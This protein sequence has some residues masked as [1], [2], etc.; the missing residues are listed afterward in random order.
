MKDRKKY[1]DILR[2]LACFFVVVN[3]FSF[4]FLGFDNIEPGSITYWIHLLLSIFCKFAVPLFFMISGALLLPKKES[5]ADLYRK[6][7]SRIVGTL[8]IA[9]CIYYLSERFLIGSDI[10]LTRM[11]SSEM[12]YH[13]WYLYAYIA[14]LILLPFL[15]IIAEKLTKDLFVYMLSFYVFIIAILPVLELLFLDNTMHINS[16]LRATPLALNIFVMPL[17]GYYLEHKLDASKLPTKKLLILWGIN[18]AC[19][20]ISAYATRMLSATTGPG[21]ETF[22]GSFSILNAIS[23]YLTIKYFEYNKSSKLSSFIGETA[24]KISPYTLGI[25]ILHMVP[26]RIILVNDQ[27]REMFYQLPSIIELVVWFFVSIII[28]Y[29]S[30]IATWI[31]R[32]IPFL[33]KYI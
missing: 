30:Y 22:L 27:L 33:A 1:L 21:E 32:K 15:R 12:L 4:G 25:Y 8:V 24:S 20:L 5:L 7:V 29:L 26:M 6:R 2:T 23:I 17:A 19:F 10:S 18:I 9:S 11:Y 31:L 13:L 3:H 14:Y 16:F 28:F